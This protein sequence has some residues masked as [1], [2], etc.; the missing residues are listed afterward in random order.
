MD[1]LLRNIDLVVGRVNSVFENNFGASQGVKQR[2]YGKYKLIKSFDKFSDQKFSNHV[3]LY[4]DPL[5]KKVIIRRFNYRFKNLK[6]F[7]ILSEVNLLKLLNSVRNKQNI[8]F[9]KLIQL[10]QK[11]GE[12]NLVRE[13]F[14]GKRLNN[15]DSHTKVK[16]LKRCMDLLGTYSEELLKKTDFQLPKRSPLEMMLF[17]P[18]YFLKSVLKDKA[19]FKLYVKLVLIF[20]K[21]CFSLN[22]F[23]GKYVIAHRDLHSDNILINGKKIQ[24][25]DPEVAMLAEED[26]D[27][28]IIARYYLS[29]L[30]EQ[31]YMELIKSRVKDKSSFLRT[32]I[33]YSFRLLDNESIEDKYF[34]EA[35]DYL[36]TLSSK[37]L[38]ALNTDR[39]SVSRAI[40]FLGLNLISVFYNFNNISKIRPAILCYH[41]IA[42]DNWTYSVG[43]KE[44]ERQI[45]HLKRNY[46]VVSLPEIIDKKNRKAGNLVAITFDDGYEDIYTNALP[47]LKKYKVTGTVFIVGDNDEVNRDELENN[48]KLL[49]I[50]QIKELYQLGWEIG[51]HTHSHAN[52]LKL[53]EKQL[54]E[55]IIQSKKTLEK[56]LGFG[57]R[58][59]AYPGG[60]YS[61]NVSGIVKEAGFESAFTVD[62]GWVSHKGGSYQLTRVQL[63]NEISMKQF[64]A[65]FT[66]LGLWFDGRLTRIFT[67][68]DFLKGGDV[69]RRIFSYE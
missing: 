52:L 59:F 21:S 2:R 43:P 15:F 69:F 60:L 34:L 11:K 45:K 65:M 23:N 49:S 67:S 33:F 53:N 5:G 55:E 57:L 51:F 31:D 19:N 62:S 40:K 61:K 30:E 6:Y 17:T 66:P 38:P 39:K 4:K 14:K 25:L 46:N 56:K 28:A 27:L 47:I 20:Y 37:I 48:K 29:E 58:Y 22:L 9:P 12:I 8:H 32:T 16:I 68:K 41:S 54:R 10:D 50:E 7:Q 13:Y 42:D 3:G 18:F 44:F 24:I 1:N 35:K 63:D 36:K 26:T 64:S